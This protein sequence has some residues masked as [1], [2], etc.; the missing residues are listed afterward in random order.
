MK[1]ELE[2]ILSTEFHFYKGH[3]GMGLPFECGDGWF[4]LLYQLSKDIQ[5]L[6]NSGV[7]IPEF[8]VSQVKEKFGT[9]RYYYYGGSDEVSDLVQKAEEASASICEVCGKPGACRKEGGWYSTLCDEHYK[10]SPR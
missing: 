1:P 6:I 3:F 5:A 10:I 9:L 2:K 4:D 8:A 7:E